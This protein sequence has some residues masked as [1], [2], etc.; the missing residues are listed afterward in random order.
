M[1]AGVAGAEGRSYVGH[2]AQNLSDAGK[3]IGS[4]FPERVV[5]LE[6][7]ARTSSSK[8]KDARRRN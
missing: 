8:P 1:V 6:K 4:S 2:S 7:P 5:G 3:L